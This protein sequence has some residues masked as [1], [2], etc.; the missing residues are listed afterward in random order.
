MLQE[1]EARVAAAR[2]TYLRTLRR[3][4]YDAYILALRDLYKARR[5]SH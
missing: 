2:K 4:D 3:V 5:S 1:L